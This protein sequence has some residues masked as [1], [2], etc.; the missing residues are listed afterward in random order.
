MIDTDTIICAAL[1]AGAAVLMSWG[2]MKLLIYFRN[3]NRGET[4]EPL[5]VENIP[6]KKM[7]KLKE[8]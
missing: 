8:L 1:L 2:V 6:G 3:P 5:F 4:K 7:R